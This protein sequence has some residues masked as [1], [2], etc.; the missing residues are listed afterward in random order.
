MAQRLVVF[1]YGANRQNAEPRH[2]DMIYWAAGAGV[3]PSG[4]RWGGIVFCFWHLSFSSV[5]RAY[6][7]CNFRSFDPQLPVLRCCDS[8]SK[9]RIY[10]LFF[11][12]S[13]RSV[14]CNPF[15]GC[16]WIRPRAS[17]S[18]IN[19]SKPS[20]PEGSPALKRAPEW[21]IRI[22]STRRQRPISDLKRPSISVCLM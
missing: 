11:G 18:D 16:C 17:N 22:Q 10:F 12:K 14:P 6:Q 8:S 21:M 2:R 15:V 3:M 5:G 20:I 9:I 19:R 4:I 7:T 1:G 13:S